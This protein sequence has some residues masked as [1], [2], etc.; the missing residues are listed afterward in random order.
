M[1]SMMITFLSTSIVS[2]VF[3]A[4]CGG[5]PQN[6]QTRM[7]ASGSSYDAIEGRAQAAGCKPGFRDDAFPL[8]LV[9]CPNGRIAFQ[10]AMSRG[11]D[12]DSSPPTLSTGEKDEAPM[13]ASCLRGSRAECQEYAE[14]LLGLPVTPEAQRVPNGPNPLVRPAGQGWF[15]HKVENLGIQASVCDRSEEV[16]ADLSSRTRGKVLEPCKAVPKAY[17]ATYGTSHESWQCSATLADCNQFGRE[18]SDM[19]SACG[20]W[21]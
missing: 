5:T 14:R 12:G 9:D 6:F 13:E 20:A 21:E 18:P 7:P 1:R 11:N 15:C 17:C 19:Q 2:I 16:C 4:G 8:L 10:R 3:V